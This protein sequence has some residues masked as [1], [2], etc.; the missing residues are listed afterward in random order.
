LAVFDFA[1]NTHVA[2]EIPPEEATATSMNGWDFT[3]K[4]AVPYRR[5]FKLTMSGMRWFLNE[6]GDGLDLLSDPKH[7]AGRLLQFYQ[8]HRKWDSFEY[9]HE[10]LGQLTCRFDA[11]VS[12]PKALPN[13][14]GLVPDFEI[15]LVHHNPS[16]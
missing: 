2:E 13:S 12:V 8:D 7:N 16:F 10:Y 6:N 9:H 5:K 1:P 15:Q 4:P 14:N 11:P 3:A